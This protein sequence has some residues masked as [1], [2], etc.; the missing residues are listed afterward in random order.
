MN[1]FEN[2]IISFSNEI[3]GKEQLAMECI[4]TD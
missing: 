4:D 2:E 3:I 1:V